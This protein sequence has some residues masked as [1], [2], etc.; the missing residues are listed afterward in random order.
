MYDF[1]RHKNKNALLGGK[2]MR[3]QQKI[4]GVVLIFTEKIN[5]FSKDPF[6]HRPWSAPLHQ[7]FLKPRLVWKL[8][9]LSLLCYEGVSQVP[10]GPTI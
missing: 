7:L 3:K 8:P 2:K 6:K 10:G 9:F 1:E 4:S 5:R